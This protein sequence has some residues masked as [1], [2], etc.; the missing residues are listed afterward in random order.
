MAAG[1]TAN[2][3]SIQ[4]EGDIIVNRNLLKRDFYSI[5]PF[6]LIFDAQITHIRPLYENFGLKI[7][8]KKIIKQGE[9]G[10]RATP[11]RPLTPIFRKNRSEI[12]KKKSI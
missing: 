1:V 6:P 9:N 2:F 12:L 10:A 4:K 5:N 3:V 7:H 8:R 11:I